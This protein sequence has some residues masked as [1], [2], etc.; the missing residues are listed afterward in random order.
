[1]LLETRTAA[2]A[3]PETFW[4]Q[5]ASAAGNAP[6]EADDHG[7][8]VL[9]VRIPRDHRRLVGGPPRRLRAQYGHRRTQYWHDSAA[10]L[11]NYVRSRFR[12]HRRCVR[13]FPGIPK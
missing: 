10:Y 3:K 7:I 13:Q 6:R 4:T 9:P 1:M 11:P 5:P 12:H 2:D 8:V